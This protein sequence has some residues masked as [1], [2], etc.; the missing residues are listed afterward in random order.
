VHFS[1]EIKYNKY[2][3]KKNAII[4]NINIIY[5]NRKDTKER[6]FIYL[7]DLD[8]LFILYEEDKN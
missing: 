3:R 2:D 4:H 6:Y 1:K 7:M 5:L 8:T